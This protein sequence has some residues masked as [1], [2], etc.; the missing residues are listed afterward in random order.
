MGLS[1]SKEEHSLAVGGQALVEGVMMRSKKHLVI[2]VRQPNE[3]ILM[4]TEE[5]EARNMFS[6]GNR[7]PDDGFGL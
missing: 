6:V 2:C 4:K 7:H 3:E 5:I 1:I